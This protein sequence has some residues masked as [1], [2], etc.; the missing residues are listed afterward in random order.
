MWVRVHVDSVT[1]VR[2]WGFRLREMSS[3]RKMDKAIEGLENTHKL[4]DDVLI[5]GSSEEELCKHTEEFLKRARDADITI[6]RSKIQ[7]GSKVKFAGFLI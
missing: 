1:C 2:L 7:A 6:S 5:E 3:A 4:V